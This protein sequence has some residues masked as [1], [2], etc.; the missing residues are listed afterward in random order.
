MR[1]ALG[2]VQ[3]AAGVRWRVAG[4]RWRAACIRWR[5]AC[6]TSLG[7][8]LSS[9]CAWSPAVCSGANRS[10]SG[11]N[12]GI[13]RAVDTQAARFQGFRTGCHAGGSGLSL[14]G[15]SAL[16]GPETCGSCAR[17]GGWGTLPGRARGFAGR[18]PVLCFAVGFCGALL[19]ILFQEHVH[20]RTHRV[21]PAEGLRADAVVGSVASAGQ[22]RRGLFL[23]AQRHDDQQRLPALRPY[24]LPPAAH[25][26]LPAASLLPDLAHGG[27]RSAGWIPTDRLQP[28][29]RGALE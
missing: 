25:R 29:V 27:G 5:A 18:D 6:L 9:L 3:R 28:G 7:A 20:G 19:Q 1:L 13:C 21:V 26:P 8:T 11:S 12:V 17:L 16:A 14:G 23:R 2:G 24:D 22:H 15:L 10:A 4:V